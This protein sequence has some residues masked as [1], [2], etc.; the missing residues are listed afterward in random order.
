MSDPAT[1]VH[2]PS[3]PPAVVWTTR[4]AL[5]G[6]VLALPAAV[7]CV[8]DPSKGAALAVGV[9]AAA[10]TGLA[11]TRRARVRNL[12]LDL[13]VGVA[14]FV[15]AV[16]AAFPVAA[17]VVLFA[18][19]VG[20]S[21]VV[22]RSPAGNVLLGLVVPVLAIGLSYEDLGDAASFAVLIGV[23]SVYAFVI[24][25]LWP[26]PAAAGAAPVAPP[27][28]PS[29]AMM[30]DYGVRLGL[31]VGIAATIGFALDL[32][33]VGWAAGACALVMRPNP[34]M[35]RM[36]G[37]DRVVSVTLGAV[38]ACFL[39][40]AGAPGWV[41][42][43]V[44]LVDLAASAGTNG[45]RWY[46]AGGFNTLLVFLM[47]LVGDP[48]DASHRFWERVGETVLGVALAF[49]FGLLVPAARARRRAAAAEAAP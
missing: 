47:L 38:V 41:I 25:L 20:A 29:R 9:L 2:P 4:K 45:S 49:V 31:A 39:V 3:P 33:H 19:A 48:Q 46:L 26:V 11:D 34:T 8:G 22:A 18:V 43:L 35:L 44:V 40:L 30:L 12:G 7:V 21:L 37:V 27:P 16:L 32:E 17:V 42:G 14:L 24:S 36:R 5:L 6:V 1:A 10:V 28:R 23:G 13:T 15:G